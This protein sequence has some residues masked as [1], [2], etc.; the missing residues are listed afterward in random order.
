M[1]LAAVHLPP[2]LAI[3]VALLGCA[4]LVWYWRRLHVAPASRR[5]IR[6][7]S[8]GT[9]VVA[10]VAVVAGLS[11]I[12]PDVAPNRYVIVWAAAFASIAIVV[13]TAILDA[14]NSVHLHARE[15]ADARRDLIDAP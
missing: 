12:D 1:T 2:M 13:C 11:F 10:G 7:V 14:M 6:R 4:W 5:R 9:M 8:L 15:V 3:P